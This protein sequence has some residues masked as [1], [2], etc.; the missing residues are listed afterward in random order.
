MGAP[1]GL[2]LKIDPATD[3]ILARYDAGGSFLAEV[4]NGLWLTHEADRTISVLR[5]T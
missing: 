1:S 3:A 2:L 5:A 4:G